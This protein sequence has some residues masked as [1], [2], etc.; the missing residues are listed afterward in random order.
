MVYHCLL[1]IQG[2]CLAHATGSS[3]CSCRVLS[4]P[5]HETLLDK[6]SQT[7]LTNDPGRSHWLLPGGFWFRIPGV[8]SGNPHLSE[9]SV[10]GGSYELAK[11]Q[12][13]LRDITIFLV[14]LF[15]FMYMD[16]LAACIYMCIHAWYHMDSLEPGL[17]TIMGCH[18]DVGNWTGVF[19]RSKQC[20]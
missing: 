17:Q 4:H 2:R 14:Y 1:Q 5:G 13:G 18:V 15:Y 12:T 20:S 16:I 10:L 8:R 7:H 11:W 19:S 6:G 9:P 3:N